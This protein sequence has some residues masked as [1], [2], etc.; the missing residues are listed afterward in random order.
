M[1]E[2]L[3]GLISQSPSS[4]NAFGSLIVHFLNPTPMF[5]TIKRESGIYQLLKLT[6]PRKDGLKDQSTT[7]ELLSGIDFDLFV[8]I[9]ELNCPM[10]Y[11]FYQSLILW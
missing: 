6:M 7:L 11:T 2:K 8:F 1:L 4:C 9:P 10:R 3:P 5:G